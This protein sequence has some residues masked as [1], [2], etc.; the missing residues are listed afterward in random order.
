MSHRVCD[1]LFSFNKTK[2]VC[3]DDDL[4]FFFLND[5]SLDGSLWNLWRFM[6]C[7]RESRIII[8]MKRVAAMIIVWLLI[9]NW[10]HLSFALIV[11]ISFPFNR[12]HRHTQRPSDSLTRFGRIAP[13]LWF[14]YKFIHEN[15]QQQRPYTSYL[16]IWRID[17]ANIG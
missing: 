11:R 10:I 1:G 12:R 2:I 16:R 5:L 9:L 8:K 15:L 17:Y 4:W 14:I 7:D 6:N 3:S 13:T